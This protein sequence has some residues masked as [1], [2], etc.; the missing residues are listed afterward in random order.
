MHDLSCFPAV[1]PRPYDLFYTTVH[2]GYYGVGFEHCPPVWI[3][4][5]A[6]T[7]GT[8]ETYGYLELA[9]RVFLLADWGGPTE[10]STW[11]ALKAMY[12]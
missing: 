2:S 6:D 9:W 5:G 4:D 3:A 10:A 1:Y 7:S 8:G 12:R 11:G